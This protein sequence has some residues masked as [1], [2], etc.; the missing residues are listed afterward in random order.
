M[1][2]AIL[3]YEKA[4]SSKPRRRRLSCN[5]VTS[6]YLPVLPGACLSFRL[7]ALIA[8]SFPCFGVS[9]APP[10]IFYGGPG[11]FLRRRRRISPV[12]PE[13]FGRGALPCPSLP[14][15]GRT[16]MPCIGGNGRR[17]PTPEGTRAKQKA[18]NAMEKDDGREMRDDK[19][20][21]VRGKSYLC[22]RN[23]FIA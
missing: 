9:P 8:L 3:D 5:N 11:V 17:R 10:E 6:P 21:F 7:C 15:N 22:S 2:A 14:E 13:N 19:F 18:H 16:G 20:A 12:A 23:S 1:R 4:A